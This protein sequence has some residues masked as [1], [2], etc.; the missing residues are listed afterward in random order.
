MASI[1]TSFFGKYD[2]TVDISAPTT[3][4]DVFTE[5]TDSNELQENRQEFR[6]LPREIIKFIE[7]K[8]KAA[9]KNAGVMEIQL[10]LDLSLYERWDNQLDR[11]F[12]NHRMQE[13]WILSR[14][15]NSG[16]R[17]L[18]L[19]RRTTPITLTFPLN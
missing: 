3:T 2:I 14:D 19:T 4:L 15:I 16:V 5:T 11:V 13:R 18:R 8:I 17:E 7:D 12:Q 6:V 9:Q 1:V 10:D